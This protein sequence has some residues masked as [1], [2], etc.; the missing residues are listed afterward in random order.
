MGFHPLKARL[1][2]QLLN[3]ILSGPRGPLHQGV[4]IAGR[5][6]PCLA[7]FDIQAR[8]TSAE[9]IATPD[10]DQFTILRDVCPWAAERVGYSPPIRNTTGHVK[11]LTE[12]S[13]TQAAFDGLG[14]DVGR[15]FKIALR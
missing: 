3:A 10:P 14:L 15:H 5:M 13:A 11:T 6:T 9:T 7:P 12:I 4:N 8:L 2:G 1:L